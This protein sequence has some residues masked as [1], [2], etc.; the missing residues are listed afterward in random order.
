M[1]PSARASCVSGRTD[2]RAAVEVAPIPVKML[3]EL[4]GTTVRPGRLD[5]LS[6]HLESKPHPPADREVA[7]GDSEDDIEDNQ[8]PP[9]AAL[10]Q[11]RS[12]DRPAH[13]PRGARSGDH[14]GRPGALPPPGAAL[15]CPG[16]RPDAGGAG[17]AADRGVLAGRRRRTA[18]DGG[19]PDPRRR[20]A[21]PA[22]RGKRHPQPARPLPLRPR[23]RRHRRPGTARGRRAGRLAPAR[24]QHPPA[25]VA[26]AADGRPH[27]AAD[28]A[29]GGAGEGVLRPT[30]GRSACR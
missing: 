16:L 24:E 11:D 9:T 6:K 19:P 25:L 21:R 29:A 26:P 17:R 4:L 27:R 28:P 18:A 2:D 22:R 8:A 20:D 12:T 30:P 13:T 1:P 14:P 23:R 3:C 10:P 15:R 5:V 7:A